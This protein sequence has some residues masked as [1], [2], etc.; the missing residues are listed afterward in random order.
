MNFF[1]IFVNWGHFFCYF[2]GH[3]GHFENATIMA[4]SAN[5]PKKLGFSHYILSTYQKSRNLVRCHFLSL[6]HFLWKLVLSWNWNWQNNYQLN[7]QHLGC[8]GF[9]RITHLNGLYLEM[10]ITIPLRSLPHSCSLLRV[11]R[12]VRSVAITGIVLD[13]YSNW[14]CIFTRDNKEG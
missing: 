14:K 12:R 8:G 13:G 9:G 5:C 2:Y 4:K 1:A 11:I 6:V 10:H 7:I 3:G